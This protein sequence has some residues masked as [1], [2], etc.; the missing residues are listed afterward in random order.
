GYA[1]VQ[2]SNSDVFTPPALIGFETYHY[3]SDFAVVRG[4][5]SSSQKQSG[6]W[7]HFISQPGYS[8]RITMINIAD[9]EQELKLTAESATGS[10]TLTKKVPP[11]Q[12]IEENV[13]DLYASAGA[14]P[15][16]GALRFEI[17]TQVPGVIT[18]LE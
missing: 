16:S 8:N 4:I 7:A 11:H 17:D 1:V 13:S 14:S 15:M 2:A 12:R 9:S 6:S 10:T 5:P 18:L 3:K